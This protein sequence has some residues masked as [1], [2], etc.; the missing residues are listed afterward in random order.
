MAKLTVKQRNATPKSKMGLPGRKKSKPGSF[1]MPDKP[2][3]KAAEMDAGISEK[4]GH[5]TPMQK[6]MIDN[7]ARKVLAGK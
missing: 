3:A 4:K 7:R 6:A 2:H 5:I 1:P